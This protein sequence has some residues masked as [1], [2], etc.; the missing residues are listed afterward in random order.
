MVHMNSRTDEPVQNGT[1]LSKNV[2][3]VTLTC[4]QGGI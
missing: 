4:A 2:R 3:R 1:V